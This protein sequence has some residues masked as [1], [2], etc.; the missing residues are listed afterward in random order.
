MTMYEGC[1][2]SADELDH[3]LAINVA[4]TLGTAALRVWAA[5]REWAAVF[6]GPFVIELGDNS[7]ARSDFRNAAWANSSRG[8]FTPGLSGMR[9]R[10]ALKQA[11]K[12]ALWASVSARP[13]TN[14]CLREVGGVLSGTGQDVGISLRRPLLAP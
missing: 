4:R 6:L 11:L 12:S 7:T 5:N 10:A 14:R 8:T 1:G 3:R 9:G 13:A 2:R